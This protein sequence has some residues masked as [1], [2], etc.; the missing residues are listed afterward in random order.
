MIQIYSNSLGAEELSAVQEV[1]DSK[2]LGKGPKEKDFREQ[3]ASKLRLSTTEYGFINANS[4][5]LVTTNS[6]TEAAFQIMELLEV[7]PGDEVVMPSMSFV[8]IANAVISRGAHVVFCDVD[9]KTLNPSL[10]DILSCV[11]D[12]TRAIFLIHYAGVPS[13]DLEAIVKECQSRGI[14]VI[15]DNANSPFSFLNGKS[16]GTFGDFGIWS[17]DAMKILVTGDGGLIFANNL[18]HIEKL[19]KTTYLGL[20][21]ESGLSS[22]VDSKWWQFDVSSPSRRSIMNDI[23][24]AIGIEQLKKVDEFISRRQEIYEKYSRALNDLDWITL[25]EVPA[26]VNSSY[27]MYHVQVEDR[28]RFARYLRNEGIYTTFRYYPLHCVPFYNSI[29][30]LPNTEHAANTTLCI[31]IHQNLTDQEVDY[32]IEKIGKWK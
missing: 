15:E 10:N 5:C 12:N 31:P 20:E 18:D 8:G 17:F 29:E 3:I 13:P 32:I 7:G 6:C 25:P 2:W 28:D 11:T 26:N 23:T 24:A 9:K 27:Y 16:T 4:D 19:R 1:F 21:T 14:I 30:S 22:T